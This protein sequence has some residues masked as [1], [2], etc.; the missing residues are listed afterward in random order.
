MNWPTASRRS[1]EYV[2]PVH[3]FMILHG[4]GVDQTLRFADGVCDRFKF[5]SPPL[6]VFDVA[7]E[8]SRGR[9]TAVGGQVSAGKRPHRAGRVCRRVLRKRVQML[10]GRPALPVRIGWSVRRRN[11]ACVWP[12]HT[13]KGAMAGVGR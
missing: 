8:S 3:K 5:R 7:V 12:L 11:Q 2:Q 4:L 10:F 6:G 13:S 1:V 9:G